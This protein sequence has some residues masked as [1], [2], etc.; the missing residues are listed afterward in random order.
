MKPTPLTEQ[1][2]MLLAAELVLDSKQIHKALGGD[3]E[4]RRPQLLEAINDLVRRGWVEPQ[5][6]GLYTSYRLIHTPEES[7]EGL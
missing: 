2:V 4:T 5:I 1:I 6:T 7:F 3:P